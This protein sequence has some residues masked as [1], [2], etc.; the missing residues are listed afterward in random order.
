MIQAHDLNK[1]AYNE[2]L[3]EILI[4]SEMGAW[5]YVRVCS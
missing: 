4:Y 1:V 2:K 3:R 5:R